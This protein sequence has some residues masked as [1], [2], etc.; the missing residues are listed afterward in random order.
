MLLI[1]CCYQTGYAD[2][3]SAHQILHI[4]YLFVCLIG[5]SQQF[6]S[7]IRRDGVFLT[8]FPGHTST[9]TDC[10]LP[11]PGI[12]PHVE[13]N[14][15]FKSNFQVKFSWK[16]MICRQYDSNPGHLCYEGSAT[17]LLSPMHLIM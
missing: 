5:F 3:F 16:G 1:T 12:Y 4:C 7:Y 8:S 17:H 2:D 6:L 9:S 15:L 14:Q 10:T 11:Q 13:E